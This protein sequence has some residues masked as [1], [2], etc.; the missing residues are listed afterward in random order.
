[1]NLIWKWRLKPAATPRISKIGAQGAGDQLRQIRIADVRDPEPEK[2]E[3]ALTASDMSLFCRM[4]PNPA[5]AADLLTVFEHGRIR[6]IL[7]RRYPGIIRQSMPVLI[8]EAK[9]IYP[10]G[11]RES[12][13][14]ALYLKIALGVRDP[15]IREPALTGA[16]IENCP[17]PS[18]PLPWIFAGSSKKPPGLRTAPP[19]YGNRIPGLNP[20]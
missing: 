12:P 6:I 13:L 15:E 20:A 16:G 18:M 7:E 11:L 14:E 9:R 19:W 8:R 2:G 5:L 3:D 17:R 4:F 1:M 10:D